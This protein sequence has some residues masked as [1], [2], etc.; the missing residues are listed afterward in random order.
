[1]K[2][3]V[4]TTRIPDIVSGL[5]VAVSLYGQTAA[6]GIAAVEAGR[7]ADAVRIFEGLAQRSPDCFDCKFYL[8]MAACAPKIAVFSS[9][10]RG[11]LTEGIPYN[12]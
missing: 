6:D 1:L 12:L 7:L 10:G 2:K 5:L 3:T 4:R 11:V 8:G 9:F